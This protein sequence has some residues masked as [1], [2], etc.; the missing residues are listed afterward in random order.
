[1]RPGALQR[2]RRANTGNYATPGA[3][4]SEDDDSE[5][6]AEDS[7][8]E[9]QR[10]YTRT[11]RTALREAGLSVNYEDD[12]ADAG[13]PKKKR[14]GKDGK[15]VVV[16]TMV[17]F[18]GHIVNYTKYIGRGKKRT[19]PASRNKK[20]KR[21]V[22][23]IDNRVY[24][25]HDPDLSADAILIHDEEPE[26]VYSKF[27]GMMIDNETRA[28][29]TIVCAIFVTESGE[30]RKYCFCNAG[31][32]MKPKLRKKAHELGYHVVKSLQAH[33]E[34]EMMLYSYTYKRKLLRM[35]CDKPHC[36]EC[37][38]LMDRFYGGIDTDNV[39]SGE[40][41]KKY[42]MHPE[43]KKATGLN[44]RPKK[45]SD[46]KKKSK[47]FG[48]VGVLAQ[49]LAARG[50]QLVANN[51]DSN[52]CLILA[53][54][55]ALG[56]PHNQVLI[57]TIRQNILAAGIAPIGAMLNTYTGAVQIIMTALD[58][59]NLFPTGARLTVHTAQAHHPHVLYIQGTA[60]RDLHIAFANAHF[61]GCRPLAP[62]IAP[63]PQ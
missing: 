9:I 8:R 13:S 20:R 3:W 14:K 29:T 37:S 48:V 28:A 61:D 40:T 30:M 54:F 4:N 23:R 42:I 12:L 62:V 27:Q 25:G 5:T 24:R 49:V 43:L 57:N 56:I 32:L 41:F 10:P 2:S 46:F 26:Q 22:P 15:P 1:V 52:N 63:P 21:L 38:Y 47:G 35:G 31:A 55:D 34:G 11:E 6:E 19:G 7:D 60:P 58:A 17:S 39:V 50:L 33:A 36:T 59:Q 53:I 45:A 18:D 16:P 44:F 51:G